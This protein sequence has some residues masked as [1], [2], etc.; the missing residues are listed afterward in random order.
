MQLTFPFGTAPEKPGSAGRYAG[1]VYSP[2]TCEDCPVVY[3]PR[4]SQQKRCPDCQYQ[5]N[6]KRGRESQARRAR[7]AYVPR[8]CADCGE[9]L[10]PPAGRG[11]LAQRCGPC[12][13]ARIIAHDKARNKERSA[14]GSRKVWD[15]R[16][17]DS[18]RE[19]INEAN[20]QY[21]RLHPE[22][23]EASNARRRQRIKAAMT[24]EDRRLSRSYRVATRRDSC[25]YCG[26]PPPPVKSHEL[27][28]FFPLGKGGTDAWV[29][30]VR[31]CLACNRGPAGKLSKCGTAF[32]LRNGTWKPLAPHPMTA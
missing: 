30:L 19:E 26:K 18:H 32:M 21:K 10:P 16:W 20:R 2:R 31:S 6:L 1:R 12:A 14:T 4:S 22:S 23:D 7:A 25:F 11:R 24:A 17:R 8:F 29:N 15:A 5:E 3:R 27:D 13:E 9:E 28:H